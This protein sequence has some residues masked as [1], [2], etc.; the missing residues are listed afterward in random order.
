MTIAQKRKINELREAFR[1]L[2]PAFAGTDNF[3]DFVAHFRQQIAKVR[4]G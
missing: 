2:A 1:T 3:D 4:A